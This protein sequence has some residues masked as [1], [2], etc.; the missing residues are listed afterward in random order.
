MKKELRF[1]LAALPV[2]LTACIHKTTIIGKWIPVSVDSAYIASF[3]LQDSDMRNMRRDNSLQ[4]LEGGK[5]ISIAPHDTLRGVYTF[6]EKDKTLAI[7]ANGGKAIKFFVELK[8]DELIISNE[9][10]KMRLQR[11]P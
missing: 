4:L 9:S 2:V 5:M 7:G 6:N 8:P 11:Q 3:H 10:G 1:L